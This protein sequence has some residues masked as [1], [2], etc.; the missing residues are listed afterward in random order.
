VKIRLSYAQ[1]VTYPEPLIREINMLVGVV[2]D[3]HGNLAGVKKLMA[4]LDS[5]GISTVIHLGDDYGDLDLLEM[6]GFQV[7]GVPGVYCPEYSQEHI[8]NRRVVDLEGASL[9]LTHTPTRHRLDAPKD[10]DPS[11]QTGQVHL[12]LYGHTHAPAIEVRQ[13]TIW[14]N[15]GHLRDRED[16]GHPPTFAVLEIFPASVRIEIF[17]LADGELLVAADYPLLSQT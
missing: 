14:L 1:K 17:R 6:A 13:G 2:S 10:S 12:V 15:P 11:A 8:P 7:I 16:R 9:F 4:H 5:R 3:T